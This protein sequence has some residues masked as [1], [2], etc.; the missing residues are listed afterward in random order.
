MTKVLSFI[1]LDPDTHHAVQELLV[2]F[3]CQRMTFKSVWK[4]DWEM[5]KAVCKSLSM[6][7]W[8]PCPCSETSALKGRRGHVSAASCCTTKALF[9]CF[10]SSPLCSGPTPLCECPK[11]N[12]NK[13]WLPWQSLWTDCRNRNRAFHSGAHHYLIQQPVGIKISFCQNVSFFGC[14]PK[15]FPS[16]LGW[17]TLCPHAVIP[18]GS[19]CLWKQRPSAG[20]PLNHLFFSWL[21][22]SLLQSSSRE[23]ILVFLNH[24][25][26]SHL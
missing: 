20:T 23:L 8:C 12:Q 3:S 24:Y 1:V 26:S 6:Y 10:E 22:K 7:K 18:W 25:V 17:V 15:S 4:W 14:C 2:G 19:A 13:K 5:H 9:H 16:P 11:F 21:P